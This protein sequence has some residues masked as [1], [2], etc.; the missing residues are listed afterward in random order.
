MTG[1]YE[2]RKQTDPHHSISGKTL[3][4]DVETQNASERV[5]L[6][7]L[8]LQ[9]LKGKSSENDCMAGLDATRSKGILSGAGGLLSKHDREHARS[10]A[11]Q[12]M[13]LDN[14]AKNA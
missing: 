8:V 10:L 12:G 14:V 9:G 3:N 7:M 11:A 1:E 4:I 2:T 6:T 13:S 5:F